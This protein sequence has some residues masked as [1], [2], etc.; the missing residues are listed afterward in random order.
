VLIAYRAAE[1]E[2]ADLKRAVGDLKHTVQASVHHNSTTGAVGSEGKAM[3]DLL[4]YL[5]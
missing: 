4:M 1:D 2:F 3:E 5:A